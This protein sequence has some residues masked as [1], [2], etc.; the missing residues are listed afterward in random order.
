MR[1]WCLLNQFLWRQLF[2]VGRGFARSDPRSLPNG[3]GEAVI[4]RW[5]VSR[6]ATLIAVAQFGATALHQQRG[7]GV[8]FG[9]RY[10]RSRSGGPSQI[11]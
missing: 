7:G 10:G 3:G 9:Q 2:E 1:L 8:L 4:G 6:Y 5:A 11:N